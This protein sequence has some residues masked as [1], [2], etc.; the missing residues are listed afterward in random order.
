AVIQHD[1]R[2]LDRLISDISDA[3]RLD[4]ELA[5]AD[6]RPVDMAI[7]LETVAGVANEVRRDDDVRISLDIAPH[8]LGRAAYVV[9]GHDSRLGQVIGNLVEN[10][11]SFSPQGGEVRVSLRRVG[12]EVEI[13]VE[14]DGPGIPPHALERIF[15]RF[16]TDR[17]DQGFG[18]NSG[19][20]LSISRQI[21][22]AHRGRIWAENRPGS[23]TDDRLGA[24]FRVRLPAAT[25]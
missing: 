14:D 8:P 12:G 18:Q 16:Y 11:R 23:N 13:A 15:E 6:A 24:I 9:T 21:V 22:V 1:V 25:R 20:G 17:P 3:S 7:L 5:R 2:R 4:A 19:L 10:A